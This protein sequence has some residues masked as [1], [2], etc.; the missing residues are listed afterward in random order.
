[1]TRPPAS[2][3]VL[4]PRVP[5]DPVPDSTTA[6]PRSPISSASESKKMSMGW[7]TWLVSYSLRYRWPLWTTMLLRGGM[8]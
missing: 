6:T 8:R 2:L 3:T 1:M 7:L 5:S 4:M